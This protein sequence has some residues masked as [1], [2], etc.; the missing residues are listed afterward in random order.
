MTKQ[1]RKAFARLSQVLQETRLH[2][3]LQE[4]DFPSE[5]DSFNSMNELVESLI[6]ECYGPRIP[7]VLSDVME[8]E[9]MLT[10]KFKKLLS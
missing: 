7:Y 5:E 10:D 2:Y 4:E 3:S 1:R 8:A 9:D 6:I